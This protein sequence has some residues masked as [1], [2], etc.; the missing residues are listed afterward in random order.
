[1][2]LLVVVDYFKLVPT[3]VLSKKKWSWCLDGWPVKILGSCIIQLSL[4]AVNVFV[5]TKAWQ[6]HELQL[7]YY[8]QN[9]HW[10]GMPSLCCSF[11]PALTRTRGGR[12]IAQS[13]VFL[14]I[15]RAIRVCARIDPLV[16]ERWNSVTVLLT[17]STQCQQLVKKRP[18]MSYYV[19]VIMHVKDP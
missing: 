9:K 12:E 3:L 6:C 8:D 4:N 16:I 1:M 18:S 15:K 19:C 5:V 17:C 10:L 2:Y 11:I 13:L 14:S 7:V